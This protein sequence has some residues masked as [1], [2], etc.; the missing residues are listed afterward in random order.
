[1]NLSFLI[2]IVWIGVTLFS[3][4]AGKK[5]G[6]SQNK[7]LGRKIFSEDRGHTSQTKSGGDDVPRRISRRET[8]KK[9]LRNTIPRPGTIADWVYRSGIM[10][11]QTSLSALEDKDND[12]LAREI[13]LEASADNEFISEMEKLKLEHKRMHNRL[14]GN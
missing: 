10:G 12:W 4:N 11:T 3:L 13:R 6:G 9:H 14:H 1:M 5:K 7:T 8:E 2:I